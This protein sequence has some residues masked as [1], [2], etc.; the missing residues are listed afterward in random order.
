MIRQLGL[1]VVAGGVAFGAIWLARRPA[2]AMLAV[3]QESERLADTAAVL[4]LVG[5]YVGSSACRW[6]RSPASIRSV[7]AALDSIRARGAR[8]G[9]RVVLMGIDLDPE[10]GRELDHLNSVGKFH[11]VALGGGPLA[12]AVRPLFWGE[13][14]G[15]PVT[16]QFVLFVRRQHRAGSASGA[17]SV[18]AD[19]P[20]LLTRK[21]GVPELERWVRDGVPISTLP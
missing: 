14:G 10:P 5:V 9:A 16:P 11:Q 19:A 21:A 3:G 12:E 15:P 13:L 18:S 1:L 20:A 4:D 17:L 2:P 7:H 6:C 8:Y